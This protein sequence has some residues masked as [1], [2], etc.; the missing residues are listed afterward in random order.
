M[1]PTIVRIHDQIVALNARFDSEMN[2]TPEQRDAGLFPLLACERDGLMNRLRGL[3]S[4]A[5]PPISRSFLDLLREAE[6]TLTE[7]RIRDVY[8]YFNSVQ[9][10]SIANVESSPDLGVVKLMYQQ[11]LN[12]PNKSTIAYLLQM[13]IHCDGNLLQQGFNLFTGHRGLVPILIKK[14][15]SNDVDG[16]KLVGSQCLFRYS[17]LVPF[18]IFETPAGEQTSATAASSRMKSNLW[19]TMPRYSVCLNHFSSPLKPIAAAQILVQ[20][21]DALDCLHKAGLAHLDVKPSNIFVDLDGACFLGDFGSV[22]PLG[23]R[24]SSTTPEFLPAHM[25]WNSRI[26]SVEHDLWMLLVTIFDVLSPNPDIRVGRAIESPA[27]ESV[28]ARVGMALSSAHID[29]VLTSAE[30]LGQEIL[31]DSAQSEPTTIVDPNSA[32]AATIF[33]RITGTCVPVS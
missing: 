32:R 21:Y 16:Y 13:G 26:S 19:A 22:R 31:L 17:N 33:H 27:S 15:G 24:V 25:R 23:S 7:S 2:K 10:T 3:I 5:P 9:P 8:H 29:R 6:P 30:F 18:E 1:D 11:F 28:V 12:S 4:S 14:L 20:I